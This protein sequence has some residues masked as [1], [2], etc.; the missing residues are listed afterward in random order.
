GRGVLDVPEGASSQGGCWFVST[1]GQFRD[2]GYRADE[3]RRQVLEAVN[4]IIDG[5][6]DG[7]FPL[8]PDEPSGQPWVSCGFCDPDGLGTRD[9]WRDWQRKQADPDLA[10]YLDL[11]DPE[12]EQPQTAG[13]AAGATP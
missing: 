13:Q 8:H 7:L 11:I 2:A 5:I 6:G 9:Q 12:R 4:T 10:R 1:K 3:A